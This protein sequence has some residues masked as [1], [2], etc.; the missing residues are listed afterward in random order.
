VIRAYVSL[1]DAF[2]S[3]IKAPAAFRFEL[4]ER[5]RH[6]SDQQGRRLAIWPD[7]DLSDAS[8]N[9]L[10]WRDF[11]RGYEFSLDC[12]LEVGRRYLLQVTCLCPSGRRLMDEFVV[13]VP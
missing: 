13:K 1:L 3:R 7:F 2:G 8:E 12:S 11:L 10:R 4:Y 6:A 5:V 9:N